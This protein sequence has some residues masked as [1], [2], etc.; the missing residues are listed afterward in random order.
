MT[1]TI[2]ETEIRN[3]LSRHYGGDNSTRE[4][5][6]NAREDDHGGVG[7]IVYSLEGSPPKGYAIAVPELR[8]VSFYDNH[9]KR[10]RIL[11]ETVVEGYEYL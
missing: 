9:G 10:F 3:R 8:M 7:S 6:K 4:L 2:D 11:D 5:V 1:T